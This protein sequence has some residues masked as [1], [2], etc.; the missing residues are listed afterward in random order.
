M[1]HP[2]AGDLPYLLGS[3]VP[4]DALARAHGRDPGA[5]AASVAAGRLP[6]PAYVLHDATE[7]A[8]PDFFALS[9]AAGGDD[10]LP[11]WFAGAYVRAAASHPDADPAESAW[12]DYLSGRYAAC[13]RSVTPVTIVRKAV[14]MARIERLVDAPRDLDPE[15][16]AELRAAVDALDVLERPF[17]AVDRRD[18]S[19]SRDRLISAVRDRF[20][21]LWIARRGAPPP[22]R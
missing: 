3:F 12:H 5:V 14:L 9:D 19:V 8:A 13:L 4:L 1:V 20:P 11:A 6:G 16:G 15:W 18:G 10:A 17:A 22:S 7:L 21:A 2:G